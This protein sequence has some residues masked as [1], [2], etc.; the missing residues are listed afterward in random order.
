MYIKWEYVLRHWCI[1]TPALK[2][3]TSKRVFLVPLNV[4][5]KP[6]LTVLA[7]CGLVIL[8][9]IS[10]TR[11]Y[12][13]SFVENRVSVRA[14]I[15]GPILISSPNAH[16]TDMQMK[17]CIDAIVFKFPSLTGFSMLVPTR[18]W[19]VHKA[20]ESPWSV[21]DSQT[22]SI[23]KMSV[24]F[25]SSRFLCWQKKMNIKYHSRHDEKNTSQ[26]DSFS[27]PL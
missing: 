22:E 24:K 14:S 25:L 20:S 12:P 16:F 6:M 27:E 26:R 1:W 21:E 13:N 8:S 7:G 15:F 17:L 19:L 11:I 3:T 23:Q 2:V 10:H 9:K 18:H 4:L 5:I